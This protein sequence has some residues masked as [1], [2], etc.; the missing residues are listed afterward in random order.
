MPL[1]Y[2]LYLGL[3]FITTLLSA[4]AVKKGNKA[5]T[6]L[7]LIL[8]ATLITEGYS[9]YAVYYHQDFSWM[10]HLFNPIEYTLFCLYYVKGTEGSQFSIVVKYSIPVYSTFSLCVSFFM[11]HLQSMPSLNINVEGLLLFILYTHLLFTIDLNIKERIY[12]HPDFWIS[13]AIMIFFGGV[14]VFLGLYPY[15]FKSNKEET[16][17][18][19]GLIT[20]PLN[21]IYYSCINI[22]L[23]CLIRRKR[24]SS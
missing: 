14:F 5:A 6:Y 8:C 19:F 16:M 24:Y 4:V 11:Y 2:K 18:L 12:H 21:I 3:I 15:L 9:T 10:Y 17:K 7:L 1:Y 13:V 20:M 23:I 22:G